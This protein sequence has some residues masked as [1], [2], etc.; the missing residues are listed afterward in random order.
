MSDHDDNPWSDISTRLQ[1]LRNLLSSERHLF[2]DH[3]RAF[4][5][6]DEEMGHQIAAN[7][8]S[9]RERRR[10]DIESHMQEEESHSMSEDLSQTGNPSSLVRSRRRAFRPSERLQ[11]YQRERLGQSSRTLPSETSISPSTQPNHDRG[12]R[13]RAKRRKLDDGTYEDEPRTFR[14][15]HKGQVVPGLLRMEIASCDGGEYSDPRVSI[16]SYPQHVLVDDASVYCTKTSRCN[17]LLKH[18]GGMPFTLTKIVIKAPRAGFD[19]PIQKGLIFVSMN[20]DNLLEK[21]SRYDLLYGPENH[22][23]ISLRDVTR[24]SREYMNSARSPLRSVDRSRY[25]EDPIGQ[26]AAPATDG[27]RNGGGL[28]DSSDGEEEAEEAAGPASPRPWQDDEYSLRS[29]VDRYR[30]L[31]AMNI[32]DDESESSESESWDDPERA[33]WRRQ[34]ADEDTPNREAR[35]PALLQGDDLHE[36]DESFSERDGGSVNDGTAS[37]RRRLG[38]RPVDTSAADAFQS[39]P[40]SPANEPLSPSGNLPGDSTAKSSRFEPEASSSVGSSNTVTPQAQFNISRSKS[41]AS[42]KF[43]P[44]LSGRYI[45]VKL[46]AQ[47]T[48]NNIDVQAI[49]PCG[50]GGPRFFPSNDFR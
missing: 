9:T 49:L 8:P 35:V 24:P 10:R 20:E 3:Q 25:L 27:S 38:R 46:W 5:A 48:N 14:Y 45:L 11:R 15:G 47:T 33:G 40:V 42:V 43:D 12:D 36:N 29:Y 30:P 4:E 6:I 7:Q 32:P 34:H 18:V 1:N 26:Y 41:R 13:L 21:A 44:P 2:T 22:R 28:T 37:R 23:Y 17:L 19:A 39:E 50:Y 16:N 31:R